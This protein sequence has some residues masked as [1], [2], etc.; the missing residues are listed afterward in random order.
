MSG[1]ESKAADE[2]RLTAVGCV[3]TVLSLAVILVSALPI[4]R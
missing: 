1:P 2:E 4:V 3:L